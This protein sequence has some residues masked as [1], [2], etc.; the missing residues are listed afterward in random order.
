[1]RLSLVKLQ[2]PQTSLCC[3]QGKDLNFNTKRGRTSKLFCGSENI[4]KG[5]THCDKY[6][7]NLRAANSRRLVTI[8]KHCYGGPD[9]GLRDK[10]D[11][12]TAW[13]HK[14]QT[15]SVALSPQANY[16]D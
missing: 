4:W 1:M 16:K 11:T 12:A 7:T 2:F 10:M 14:K 5:V 8:L 13:G 3:L 6:F 9:Q 15:N